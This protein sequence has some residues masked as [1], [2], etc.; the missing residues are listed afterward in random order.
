MRG[1]TIALFILA[2]LILLIL[3]AAFWRSAARTGGDAGTFA[4]RYLAA[5]YARDY[6]RIYSWLSAEDRHAK[7][8]AEYLSEN[9]PFSGAALD[10]SRRLAR[11]IE[12][13][14]VREE[15]RGERTTVRFSFRAPDA[16]D[17]TVEQLV[18]DFDPDR[19]G[20]L[21]ENDRRAIGRRLEAMKEQ[22][23]LAMID[24]EDRLELARESGEWKIV[25]DW[26]GAI[27]V[28]F[29]GEVKEGLAWD[30]HPVKET[31]LAKP[32]ETLRVIYTAKNLSAQE[33]TGKARHLDEPKDAE[34]YLEII[35]CFCFIRERLKPG[36]T[37]ELPLVFR[38]RGEVPK[39]IKEFTLDYQFYP[40]E[41]FPAS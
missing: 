17:E 39:D 15:T 8:R 37:K 13:T 22:N 41:K 31:V 23:M 11:M 19:L 10:M 29:K 7:S 9:P 1:R 34:K 33:L 27:R 3:P 40:I 24:G 21:S 26:S 5:L 18:Y 38:I 2:L 12:I 25:T 6:G 35:Q 28:N 20:R 32:G 4:R 16:N 30:F 36:E 14:N